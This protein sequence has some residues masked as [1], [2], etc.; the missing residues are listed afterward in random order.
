VST[1][2]TPTQRRLLTR[3]LTAELVRARMAALAAG[4]READVNA[5]TVRRWRAIRAMIATD[6]GSADPTA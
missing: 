3:L 6:T 4:A 1:G 5:A 2:L